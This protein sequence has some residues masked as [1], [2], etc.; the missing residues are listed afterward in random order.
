MTERLEKELTKFLPESIS[1]GVKVTPPP[2]GT[3]SAWY[4]ARWLAM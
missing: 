4:G 1:E 3:D 2:Y